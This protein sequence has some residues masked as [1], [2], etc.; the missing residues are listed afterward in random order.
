MSWRQREKASR[1][2]IA[3]AVGGGLHAK[4]SPSGEWQVLD[5]DGIPV[6]SGFD[7][8]AEAKKWIDDA[9]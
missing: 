7:D 5:S 9:K 8:E 3:K 1:Q 2:R 4:R 6:A